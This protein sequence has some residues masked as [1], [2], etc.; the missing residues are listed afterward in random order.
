MYTLALI[1]GK[2]YINQS[3]VYRNIYIQDEKIALISDK[4]YPALETYDANGYEILPGMIDPHVHFELD[5]G[6]IKSVDNFY[7]GSVS[8]IYGGITSY[9]DF[10]EPVDTVE[11]LEKA[12]LSR[13][14]QAR[15]S[16]ADYHF[17]A[18][19]KNPKCNL[20]QF[21]LKMKSLG[22]HTLKLFTT[23]SDSLRRTGDQDIIELL[24]LSKKHH[25]LIMAHIENDDLIKLDH[26]Y[27]YRELPISRDTIAEST[28]ALKL[29][30]FVKETD[31][32][33]YMVHLSSGHTLMGLIDQYKDLINKKFFIESC[34]QYFTF[35]KDILN[36]ENGYLY[37]FAPPLRSIKEKDLLFKH[38]N[39][40]H[41]IGTD[42]CAFMKKDKK[43][44]FLHE[45]PLGIGGIEHSFSIMRHHLGDQAIEKMT[46]HVAQTQGLRNKGSIKEGYDADFMIFK[47]IPN[48]IISGLHGTCDYS[49]YEGLQGSGKVISTILRGKFILKNREFLGGEGKWI[50]GS[51]FNG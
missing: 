37:T 13:M 28:E 20:E 19:I 38:S 40:I 50:E 36:T 42:H 17:H 44:K 27:T 14:S 51:D 26:R 35:T 9:V 12:F 29:A 1:H 22:M 23:Y 8:A 10:L 3:F 16:V 7:S 25:F 18:T 21:I 24:K 30:K 5:L 32:N 2:V 48:Q 49:V 15:N 45:T 39:Y 34:P 11:G 31:G 43:K 33:L 46:N 41:T 6:W 4:L 47:P